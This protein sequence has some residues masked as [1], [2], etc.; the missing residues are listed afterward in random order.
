MSLLFDKTPQKHLRNKIFLKSLL[1]AVLIEKRELILVFL[2]QLTPWPWESPILRQRFEVC[3][4]EFAS[5][6]W[7]VCINAVLRTGFAGGSHT[8][9]SSAGETHVDREHH[10]S[11]VFPH[12]YLAGEWKGFSRWRDGT[13]RRLAGFDRNLRSSRRA[14]HARQQNEYTQSRRNWHAAAERKS[15]ARGR[16]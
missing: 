11:P 6:G 4:N 14:V 5:Q 13:K 1:P 3:T 12:S 8:H 2:N 15:A 7:I 9:T 10:H 16:Q